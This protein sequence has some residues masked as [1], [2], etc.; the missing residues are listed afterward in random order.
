MVLDKIAKAGQ[1]VY[2]AKLKELLEP[3]SNRRFVAIEP[4]T[5]SYFIGASILEALEK[6]ELSFPNADFH[7]VRI[8]SPAAVSFRHKVVV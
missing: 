8:G 1:E 6:G 3:E 7:V 2:D 4:S 5:G